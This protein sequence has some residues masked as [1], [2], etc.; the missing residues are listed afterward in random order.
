VWW[1]DGE[2]V[3][4]VVGIEDSRWVARLREAAEESVYLPVLEESGSGGEEAC[5]GRVSCS[6]SS[7]QDFCLKTR[8][9]L[10]SAVSHGRWGSNGVMPWFRIMVWGLKGR[11]EADGRVRDVLLY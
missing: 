8:D 6:F 7:S 3:V 5:Q 9:G 10:I 11:G 2:R 4:S 1:T